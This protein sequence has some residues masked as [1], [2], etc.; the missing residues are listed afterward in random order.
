MWAPTGRTAT[1]SSN[2][3]PL[4]VLR[5]HIVVA[6]AFHIDENRVRSTWTFFC[7]SIKSF[8]ENQE[9]NVVNVD[10]FWGKQKKSTDY[11]KIG[12]NPRH[13]GSLNLKNKFFLVVVDKTLKSVSEFLKKTTKVVYKRI[14]RRNFMI[15]KIHEA[16]D[17]RTCVKFEDFSWLLNCK[18]N[19]EVKNIQGAGQYHIKIKLNV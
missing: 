15:K 3:S 10:F 5:Y 9:F 14:Q 1:H 18:W 13:R 2:F 8:I 17:T 4:I 6:C 12:N 16:F 11:L 19:C 7:E